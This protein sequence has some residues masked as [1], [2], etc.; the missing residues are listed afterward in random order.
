M[1]K[2]QC[3]KFQLAPE[4]HATLNFKP[5]TLNYSAPAVYIEFPIPTK[6]TAAKMT[7]IPVMIVPL[8]LGETPV[9]SL[10]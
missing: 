9:H 2:V 4:R 3:L 8:V 10:R 6:A 1:F 7:A 5:G